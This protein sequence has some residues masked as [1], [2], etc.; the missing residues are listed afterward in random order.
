MAGATLMVPAVA[1]VALVG[2]AQWVR[3]HGA[4]GNAH[5]PSW[6]LAREADASQAA[7]RDAALAELSRRLAA[8]ELSN[9]R[10]LDVVDRGLRRQADA[11]RPWTTAWGDFIEAA[12]AAGRVPDETWQRYARQAVEMSYTIEPELTVR[13]GQPLGVIVTITPARVAA[14]SVL[15][16]EYDD[17]T[18]NGQSAGSRTFRT[19]SLSSWTG[20]VRVVLVKPERF[21]DLPDGH[22]VVR[23][24]FT[25]FEPLPGDKRKTVVPSIEIEAPVYLRTETAVPPTTQGAQ[26]Q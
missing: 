17:A 2:W 10:L 16:V 9:A 3:S 26:E 4:A 6:W 18:L 5:K 19:A 21:A 20:Q 15:H 7:T 13:R 8:G 22:H 14:K 1:S 25:V 12:R 24:T 11:R 23:Q